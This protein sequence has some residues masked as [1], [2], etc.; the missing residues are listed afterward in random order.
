MLIEDEK[1]ICKS[2]KKTRKNLNCVILDISKKRLNTQL[3]F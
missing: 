2:L 1:N 3:I